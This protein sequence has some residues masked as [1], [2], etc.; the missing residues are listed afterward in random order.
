MFLAE[1]T[2][3]QPGQRPMP[4]GN[5]LESM[6]GRGAAE[7][8]KPKSYTWVK[9]GCQARGCHSGCHGNRD[10]R[11]AIRAWYSAKKASSQGDRLLRNVEVQ[12]TLA[13]RMKVSKRVAKCDRWNVFSHSSHNIKKGAKE[14][15]SYRWAAIMLRF[16]AAE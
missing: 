1:Q 16:R 14:P 10:N 8:A 13:E 7:E 15:L 9:V 4:A 6:G 12:A 3:V 5:R 11:E 2:G